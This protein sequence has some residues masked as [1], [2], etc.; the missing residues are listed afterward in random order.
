MKGEITICVLKKQI[1]ERSVQF[2]E[3]DE[4][5]FSVVVFKKRDHFT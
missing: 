5:V 2:L 3:A 4:L 1:S